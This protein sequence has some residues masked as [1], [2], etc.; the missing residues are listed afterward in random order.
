MLSSPCKSVWVD[1][2]TSPYKKKVQQHYKQLSPQQP[3]ITAFMKSALQVGL[4]N[5]TLSGAQTAIHI[6]KKIMFDYYIMF[7]QYCWQILHDI[8]TAFQSLI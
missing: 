7:L 3:H 1:W 5:A 2:K 4:L 8:L 6:S